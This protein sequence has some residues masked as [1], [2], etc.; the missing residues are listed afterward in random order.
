MKSLFRR[1][2]WLV[3]TLALATALALFFAVRFAIGVVYWSAHH[4]EPVQAWMTVRYVG[5]SW[6]VNPRLVSAKSGL[7]EPVR[8]HPVTL[9][10]LAKQRGVPVEAVIH[11]VEAAVAAL[12]TDSE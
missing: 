10:E 2:P 9:A 8:G 1:H 11:E 4:K 6:G 12:K 5:K 3:S 7:P